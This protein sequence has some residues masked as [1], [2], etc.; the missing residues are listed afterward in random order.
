MYPHNVNWL[1]Q[2]EGQLFDFITADGGFDEKEQYDAKEIL[3]YN[4]IFGEIVAILLLQ[5]IGGSCIIKIF[6]TFTETTISMLWLLCEHY[7]SFKFVKPSTSRPTNAEKYVICTKFQGLKTDGSYNEE[8]LCNLMLTDITKDMMLDIQIP[9]YFQETIIEMSQ[10]FAQQQIQTISKVITFVQENSHGK[11][12][13]IYI[14][15][16][17]YSKQKKKSFD[18]WKKRFAFIET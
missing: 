13:S 2:N 6:E 15:K 12:G 3:H 18:E 10:K 9:E 16:R 14:D 4:L 7:D 11:Y 17:Q 5:K 1:R 8:S